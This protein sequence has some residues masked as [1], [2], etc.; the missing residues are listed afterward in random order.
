MISMTYFMFLA[1]K[2]ITTAG[3]ASVFAL[4]LLVGAS[5]VALAWNL[6]AYCSGAPGSPDVGQA[7]TWTA[8]ASSTAKPHQGYYEYS[9]S[10][11]DGLSGGE[12]VVEK[13]YSSSG[14]KM[15]K[16]KVTL[17]LKFR[18]ARE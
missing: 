9:W 14:E 16:V 5:N 7:V 18:G 11:S 6:K 3:I 10:G 4:Y 13:T 17:V 2:K 1:A 15:A 8:T 12:K